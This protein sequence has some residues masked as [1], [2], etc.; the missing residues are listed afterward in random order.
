MAAVAVCG[1]VQECNLAARVAVGCDCEAWADSPAIGHG[2]KE[3]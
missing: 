2:P 3:F 1:G